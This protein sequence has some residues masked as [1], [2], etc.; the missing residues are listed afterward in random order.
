MGT[1]PRRS[2]VSNILRVDLTTMGRNARIRGSQSG[3]WPEHA[4][5]KFLDCQRAAGEAACWAVARGNA[6]RERGVISC[7]RRMEFL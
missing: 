7:S 4:L 5:G 6:L 1:M 2:C 3:F